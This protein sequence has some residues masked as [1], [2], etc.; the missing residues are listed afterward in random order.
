MAFSPSKPLVLPPAIISGFAL[1]TRIL[2]QEEAHH[3]ALAAIGTHASN[4]TTPYIEDTDIISALAVLRD[5]DTARRWSARPPST[6]E[7]L[8][9][10]P[11]TP[12]G[13]DLTA[14]KASCN[15]YEKRL[16]PGI[17]PPSSIRTTFSDVH[18][19]P[20]TISALKLL[21]SLSL[22]RP[23]AF[24]YGV[25][26]TDSIPGL[27]LYGP[28][29]NGKTH[30]AKAVAASSGA[31]MLSVSGSEINDMYVGESEKN[32]RAI[33]TL[34]RKLAPC[35]VFIDEADS[36]F[37]SRGESRARPS[38]RETINQFLKEWDGMSERAVFLMVATNRPF[39]LDD[40]VLRRL[41]RRLLVDLPTQT[42]REAILRIHLG[43]EK[44]DPAVS[45]ADLAAQTPFYSG[46]DLKNIA[47][48][49]ALAAVK[50]ESEA[51]EQAAAKG[52]AY[53][54][55]ERRVLCPRHFEHALGQISASVGE[56]MQSLAAIRKFD[57]Q[58]GERRG[59]RARRAWGFG[60]HV[61]KEEAA[62]VRT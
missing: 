17:I 25:L 44:L 43:A 34:A 47:V 28:P 12:R 54:F 18:V 53:T 11:N 26:R 27:L 55:P 14:L 8:P 36:I 46:S 30:L 5:S 3:I 52:E 59:R 60:Q 35:I 31:T 38:H 22:T 57:E 23:D 58:Y 24:T 50:E 10:T 29:G 20:A 9:T 6:P 48:A 40:A 1:D 2:K 21:T 4:P 56:D 32:V 16:L 49:A 45:I 62:R 19:A 42:D 33:F 51:A 7:S 39:D 15:T 37:A 61:V 13:P 41:P